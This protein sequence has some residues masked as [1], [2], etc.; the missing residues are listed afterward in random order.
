MKGHCAMRKKQ[1]SPRFHF[2]LIE[3]LVVIAIIA[4]LAGMLLPAL[5]NARRAAR[6]A[7]C[8]GNIKQCGAAI[9]HYALDNKDI[10]VPCNL[11]LGGGK[12]YANR[13]FVYPGKINAC[14]WT[15][16]VLPYLAV[17]KWNL[18]SNGDYRYVTIS[19]K[20]SRGIMQ[21]PGITKIPL[22]KDNNG[23]EWDYRYI[24]EISYG[25]PAFIGG[26]PD[27]DANGKN[28]KKF[29]MTFSKLKR[30]SERAL[31]VDSVNSSAASKTADTSLLSTQGTFI[32]ANPYNG[33]WYVSTKRHG[34]KTNIVFADGHVENVNRTRIYSEL[35]KT[36][37][38]ILFWAGAL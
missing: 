7:A 4:I 18:P 33:W 6:A 1:N 19:K 29:P 2:T 32:V 28:V 36:Y 35:A 8:Q 3:L 31:L 14:P 10:I 9:L 11:I 13:G 37:S 24:S 30:P 26:G 21:C 15:W 34:G 16:W 27:Y 20:Y 23:N 12:K 22:Y 17:K 5:N 25:M 38:G